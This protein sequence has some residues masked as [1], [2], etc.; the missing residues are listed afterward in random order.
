MK[1]LTEK[2]M[3]DAMKYDEQQNYLKEKAKKM[4]ADNST[5]LLAEA[6]AAREILKLREDKNKPSILEKTQVVKALSYLIGYQIGHSIVW[7][8]VVVIVTY[9]LAVLRK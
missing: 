5:E 4:L 3:V 2:E 6:E 1:N 9:I 7:G 8:T